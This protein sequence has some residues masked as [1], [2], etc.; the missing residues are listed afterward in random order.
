MFDIKLI[1][2]NYLFKHRKY[3]VDAILESELL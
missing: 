2:D 1:M 3:S